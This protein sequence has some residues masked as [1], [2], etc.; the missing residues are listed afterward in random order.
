MACVLSTGFALDCRTSIGGVDQVWIGELDGLNTTTFA[1]ASGAVTVMAMTGG[2]K[3]YN[4]K[5][6]KN[7]SEAKA[8]TAGDVANGAGYTAQSVQIQLD[9]FDV[10]KRNEIRILGQKPVIIIV[11]D[12]NGLLSVYGAYNGLDL[13]PGGTGGTGKEAN[14]LNGFNLTFMGEETDYPY[15]ISQSIVDTLVV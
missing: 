5:L 13:Q 11:K 1:V 8:D 12:K 6:R 15:G 10:A 2:K 3:F 14:S 9:K 4:Y 7:T